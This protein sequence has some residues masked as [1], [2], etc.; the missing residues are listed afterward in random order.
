MSSG[1]QV[2]DDV[3][4][5]YEEIK[6]GKKFKFV[7]FRISDNNTEIITHSKAGCSA[8]YQDFLKELP[9]DDCRY[10]VFDFD[11]VTKEGGQRNKLTFFV[12]APDSAKIKQKMLYAASKDAIRKKLLGIATEIQATDYDEV[13]YDE[14][15]EKVSRGA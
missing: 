7:I 6:L 11:Y 9:A 1:V 12:W 5:T 8:N 14:V 13:D 4:K 2:H 10:A 15:L 3:I